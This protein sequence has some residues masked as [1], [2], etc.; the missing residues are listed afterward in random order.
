LSGAAA[1]PLVEAILCC[2]AACVLSEVYCRYISNIHSVWL[3]LR[4]TCLRACLLTIEG[5]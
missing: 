4:F 3:A 5:R 1:L 2:T